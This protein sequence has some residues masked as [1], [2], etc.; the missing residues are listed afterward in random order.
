[1]SSSTVGAGSLA[2]R[3][4]GTPKEFEVPLHCQ[5]AS[6]KHD[7]Q[8]CQSI[9]HSSFEGVVQRPLKLLMLEDQRLEDLPV[10]SGTNDLFRTG[11]R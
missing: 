8:S 6:V 5:V 4:Y 1:M 11:E 10:A 9:A 3:L 2:C 7:L